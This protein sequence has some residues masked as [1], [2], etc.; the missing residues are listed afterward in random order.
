MLSLAKE[1]HRMCAEQDMYLRP[2]PMATSVM[3]TQ[4]VVSTMTFIW[5][6]Q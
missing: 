1:G 3:A 2:I 6:N 5:I 4:N